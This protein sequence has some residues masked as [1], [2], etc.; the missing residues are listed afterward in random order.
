MII[1]FLVLVLVLL[2]PTAY[3]SIVPAD[4][5]YERKLGV[6][7]VS[8]N[9]IHY[10][11]ILCFITA[12]ACLRSADVGIDLSGH[13]IS[14]FNT[15]CSKPWSA[16]SEYGLECGM[17]VLSKLISIIS[18]DEQAFIIVTSLISYVLTLRF[19]YR[20]STDIKMSV[21]LFVAYCM[22]YQYMNQI[23]QMIALSVILLG[24]DFLCKDKKVAF[25]ISVLIATAFHTTAV[26][27]ILFLILK[28]FKITR[29]SLIWMT[30]AVVIASVAYN[31][32]F[33]VGSSILPQYSWYIDSS[34][35]GVGDTGFGII[36]KIALLAGSLLWAIYLFKFKTLETT[37][38]N[39]D[40]YIMCNY[41][42]LLFQ[43]L[44]I[45]MIVLNRMGN[46][47]L[48]FTFILVGESVGVNDS[49]YG[50]LIRQGIYVAMTLYFIYM[51]IVWGETS[52]G[53]VPYT[54]F[55]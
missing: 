54:I 43:T 55:S 30:V 18:T 21:F 51:T 47:F 11:A 28:N 10:V 25:V 16:I 48:P 52:Y 49:R 27:C 4:C 13:Y 6:I 29:K 46:Y 31:F 8:R 1:Y 22:M 5:V 39:I 9:R 3:V 26:F 45:R 40:F 42:A 7:N 34:R 32:V 17:F 15:Y 12:I 33:T 44:T 37:L 38:H 23:S 2:I 53:V 36:I 14:N 50:N 35:H 19:F 20:H 24:Y 41:C